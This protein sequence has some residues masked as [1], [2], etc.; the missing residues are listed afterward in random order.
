LDRRVRRITRT[1]GHVAAACNT[2]VAASR[3][4]YVAFLEADDEWLPGKLANQVKFMEAQPSVGLVFCEFYNHDEVLGTCELLSTQQTDVLGALPKDQV[5]PHAFRIQADLRPFLIK[6]NFI[7]RSSVIVRRKLIIEIGG[8][9]ESLRG[10]D[11][12]DLWFRMGGIVQ[13]GY[14]DLPSAM[15]HKRA[16]SMSRPTPGWCQAVVMSRAKT[17]NAVRTNP[18]IQELVAPLESQ[19]CK[20]H[21]SLVLAHVRRWEWLA[22][23]KAFGRSLQYGFD[24]RSLFL[25]VVGILGPIPFSLRRSVLSVLRWSTN[26]RM[27]KVESINQCSPPVAG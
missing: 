22:G 12:W 2:G 5:A 20:L 11:D 16:D 26:T 17:L 23:C 4:E 7:L 10:D 18:E 27:H 1:N 25:L 19:L 9:D 24:S 15:R 3:G 21:R 8:S 13:F 6:S 14:L